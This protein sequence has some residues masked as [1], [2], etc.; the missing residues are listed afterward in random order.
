[1]CVLLFSWKQHPKYPF[2][3][4]SNR[5]EHYERPTKALHFWEDYPDVL[6]GR[7]L[8][9]GGSWMGFSKK[10]RFAAITNYRN[11][12]HKGTTLS[13]GNLVKDF[14]VSDKD[15]AVFFE[16]MQNTFEEYNGFNF[17]FGVRSS[18]Y[19]CNNED[20][21]LVE[22]APG[23][24]GISNAV[25]DTPWF[26]IELGKAKLKGIL[27]Q[28]EIVADNIFEMLQDTTQAPDDLLP[29]TGISM[30][31]EKLLSSLF[32]K[33]NNYGTCSSA[34]ITVDTKKTIHFTEKEYTVGK[35][36]GGRQDFYISNTTL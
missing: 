12:L 15:P 19:Y 7:D 28:E 14:L 1:M 35:R 9:A 10:H 24:Y 23:L 13:R 8:Q 34:L 6:A 26:K 27:A 25:L 36:K 18:L 2:V 30:E 16:S 17:L 22:I 5:D 33:S 32:I 21:K 3:M 4:A 20:K 11:G 29:K 31:R